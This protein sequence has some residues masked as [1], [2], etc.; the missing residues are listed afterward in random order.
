M[1]LFILT[2]IPDG[3][4]YWAPGM[5]GLVLRANDLCDQPAAT[6]G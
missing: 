5:L 2:H 3:R 1:Y 4:V 6:Y